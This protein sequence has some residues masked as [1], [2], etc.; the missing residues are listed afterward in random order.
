MD[1]VSGT[2]PW[3][4]TLQ[5][6]HDPRAP[7]IA[8]ATLRAIL[9]TYELDELTPT[10]ELLTSELV[11]NAHLHGGSNG[12]YGLR[13]A[14]RPNGRLRVGV[15]D[16]N[17][18]IP[19]PFTDP[20]P[21]FTDPRPPLTTNPTAPGGRGLLLLGACADRYGAYTLRTPGKYLWAECGAAR[22]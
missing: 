9:H 19:P 18:Q 12:P 7:R 6:A 2:P 20:H 5:L 15:W 21:P 11:T 14:P 8:R 4:Y 22:T 17:P 13:I 10:A 16:A 3:A 1:T